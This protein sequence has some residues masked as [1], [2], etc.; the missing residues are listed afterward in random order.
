MGILQGL[1]RS[2]D[3][4]QNRTAGSGYSF[5][6]GGTTSGKAVTERSA[7]QMTAVYACVRILS[8]AIAGLP[9][10]LYRSKEDGGD[11]YLVNGNML[12]LDNITKHNAYFDED[13]QKEDENKD[14]EV[15][16]LD[17]PNGQSEGE[18]QDAVSKRNNR[19]RELV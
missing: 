15:L 17:E 7:M 5:F 4:P 2:R 10:H 1:F 3:K 12:P 8:E 16:E 6:F 13:T 14:E 18:R 9:L 19:R 11:L